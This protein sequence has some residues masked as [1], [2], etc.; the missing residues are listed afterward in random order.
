MFYLSTS[1]RHKVPA[2]AAFQGNGHRLATFTSNCLWP[3]RIRRIK[4]SRLR[5]QACAPICPA[6]L[7]RVG[8]AQDADRAAL[9]IS[10]TAVQPLLTSHA[11]WTLKPV[12]LSDAAAAL[13]QSGPA[14]W[15]TCHRKH[16]ADHS[17]HPDKEVCK[18]FPGLCDGY[19]Y[20][21]QVVYEE[22]RGHL[23]LPLVHHSVILCHRVLVR[24]YSLSCAHRFTLITQGCTCCSL[25]NC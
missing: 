4:L 9:H 10:M 3:H 14:E 25:V 5:S 13:S 2:T 8:R 15:R 21:R 6:Y 19:R 18:G 12:P 1:T 16:A 20:G 24:L 7:H 11:P 17:A 22:H 23:H